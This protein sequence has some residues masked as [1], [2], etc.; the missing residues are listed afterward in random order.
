MATDECLL[1]WR[2]NVQNQKCEEELPCWF[3]L[4]HESRWRIPLGWS[5]KLNHSFSSLGGC[6]L[7]APGLSIQMGLPF[8]GLGEGVAW[9]RAVGTWIASNWLVDLVVKTMA[10]PGTRELYICF[11]YSSATHAASASPSCGPGQHFMDVSPALLKRWKFLKAPCVQA[12]ACLCGQR[13]WWP[14]GFRPRRPPH[15]T[16]RSGVSHAAVGVC[17]WGGDYSGVGHPQ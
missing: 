1:V 11:S 3:K 2:Y 4:Q 12:C 6:P 14:Q 7:S 5:A 10:C 16:P 17:T 13:C 8:G 9:W 15:P